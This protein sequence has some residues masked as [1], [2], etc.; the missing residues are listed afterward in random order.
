MNPLRELQIY[1]QSFWIDYIRRG[2]IT[3]GELKRMVEEDGLRGVTSNP[4]IFEQA[5]DGSTDYDEELKRL[6]NADPHMDAHWIYE[7][8]SIE[9]IR[10]AADVLRTVYEESGGADGYVSIEASPFLAHDT[11]ATISEALRLWRGVDRPNVMIKVPG[12]REGIPAFEALISEGVNVNVTLLFSLAHY[13]AVANAYLRAV[14]R[15]PNP[16]QIASVASMFL[17]RIDTAVDNVLARITG[18]EAAT[19]RGKIAVCNAKLVYRRFRQIFRGPRFA[20]AARRGV[21]VQRPLWASTGTKNPEYPDT[22]YVEELI[23]P[24]TVNTMPPKTLDAF[25]DHGRVRGVTVEEETGEADA[26]LD[27]LARLG[28]DLNQITQTLQDEGVAAFSTSLDKLLATLDR[29]SHAIQSV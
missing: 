20:A 22:M 24:D 2:M 5:I 17:S 4:T 3:R 15:C 23:G 7:T 8:L 9:D 27:R 6:R 16:Q 18:P 10:M 11:Q 28:V 14:E 12:T 29:K 26:R 19:L 25:R 1:G 21:K 13:E